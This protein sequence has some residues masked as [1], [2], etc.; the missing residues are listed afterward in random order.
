MTRLLCDLEAV[1]APCEKYG[2]RNVWKVNGNVFATPNEGV[3]KINLEF[4]TC[5]VV[6]YCTAFYLVFFV[7]SW[8]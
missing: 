3:E 4:I 2:Y 1:T 5:F 6:L 7:N 8:N